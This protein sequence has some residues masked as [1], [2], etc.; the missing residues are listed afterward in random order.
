MGC[1]K[2]S[3]YEQERALE[4]NP[5]FFTSAVEKKRY[6]EKN[7]L[8]SST[9]GFNGYEK[10]NE[11]KGAGNHYSFSDYGLDPRT[12]RRWNMDPILGII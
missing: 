6:A 4:V 8:S 12:G 7:R 5:I 9:Y 2:L 1:L 11:I 10:D 3:Y